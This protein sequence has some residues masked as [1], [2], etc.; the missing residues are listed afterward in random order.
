[1]AKFQKGQSGN[2]GG[3]PKGI[4]ARVKALGG[5]DGQDY[6]AV[7]DGIARGTLKIG[8]TVPG[9]KD[10]REAAI[11]LLERGWGKPTQPMSGEGG[12]PVSI[13]IRKYGDPE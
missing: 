6:L 12:G 4:V 10:R 2:P 9:F 13:V 3:R 1:M 11:A 5:E 8:K 7:L